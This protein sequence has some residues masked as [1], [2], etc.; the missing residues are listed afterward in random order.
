M[1][2]QDNFERIEKYLDGELPIDQRESLDKEMESNPELR[3]DFHAHQLARQVIEVKIEDGLRADFAK[4]DNEANQSAKVIG[5]N[6]SAKRRTMYRRYAAAMSVLLIAA[7]GIGWLFSGNYSNNNLQAAYYEAPSGDR[8]TSNNQNSVTRAIIAFENAEFQKCIEMLKLIDAEN[9]RFE[10]AQYF[11]GHAYVEVSQFT[12]AIPA[13]E[14][15]A[16]GNDLKYKEDAEWN[17]VLAKLAANQLD[18][19]FY[20]KLDAIVN[21]QAHL[22]N[23]EAKNLKQDLNNLLRRIFY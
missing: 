19:G 13:F 9:P 5:I 12:Y 17:L 20:S 23:A 7:F 16:G 14:T 4:W 6:K 15:V 18:S 10:E 8:G 11:L 21:D 3:A 1:T 2:N 22:Y